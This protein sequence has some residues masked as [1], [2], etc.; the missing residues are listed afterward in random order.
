MASA[1][2]NKRLSSAEGG[3]QQRSWRNI[4]M[5][6]SRGIGVMAK[7]SEANI[8]VKYRGES[9]I[10]T[11]IGSVINAAAAAGGYEAKALA[12]HPGGGGSVSAWRRG[13]IGGGGETW[14]KWL[15]AAASAK[16]GERRKRPGG[17]AVSMHG[18]IFA[19]NLGSSGYGSMKPWREICAMYP[20]ESNRH[21]ARKWRRQRRH[22]RK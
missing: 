14:R 16:S 11:C 1:G 9:S 19:K 10:E 13:V 18:A 6:A 4:I 2:G 21:G 20:A 8:G 3:W 17:M 22:R 15:A 12:H 5:A 7:S